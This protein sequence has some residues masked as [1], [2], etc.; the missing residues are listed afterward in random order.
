[1]TKKTLLITLMLV[2]SIAL[3]GCS[4]KQAECSDE[5]KVCPDGSEVGRNTGDGCRFD[6][7]TEKSE[8]NI[9]TTKINDETDEKDKNTS[10]TDSVSSK[11]NKIKIFDIN[12]DDTITSP[13]VIKGEG[14][15]NENSLVVE[16]RNSEHVALVK[17]IVDIHA[18]EVGQMGSFQVTL[19][20]SFQN[21]KEGY[22]A[23]YEENTEN[24]VEIPVKF[25]TEQ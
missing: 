5:L 3:S 25:D 12:I 17:E 10:D 19:H 15:A 22:I 24:L 20:F 13:V 1:M 2:F 21:T 11:N 8:N 23:V 16:L 6:S 4:Q 7:C 14:A 9:N 18:S